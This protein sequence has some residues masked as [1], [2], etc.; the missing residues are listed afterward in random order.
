[1][2]FNEVLRQLRKGTIYTQEEL[3][4]KLGLLRSTY[5]KYETGEN[6]PDYKTL[7][8]IANYYGVSTDV[9]LGRNVKENNNMYNSCE[10]IKLLILELGVSDEKFFD[11][12]NWEVLEKEDIEDIQKYFEWIVHKAREKKQLI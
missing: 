2:N 6:E 3:A 1:M 9:L 7:V 4:N 5:A 12:E 8:K 11:I 10:E